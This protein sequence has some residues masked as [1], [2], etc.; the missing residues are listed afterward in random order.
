VTQPPVAPK[1]TAVKAAPKIR[2][3]KRLERPRRSAHAPPATPPASVPPVP[4]AIQQDLASLGTTT[5]E[6]AESV[7]LIQ[8]QQQQLIM[9]SHRLQEQQQQQLRQTPPTTMSPTPP[10]TTSAPATKARPVEPPAPTHT[11]SSAKTAPYGNL[12]CETPSGL[13]I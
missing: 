1:H 4:P 6:L 2:S 7:R 3:D 11:T 13:T 12:V 9:E 5:K 10:P 8:Q